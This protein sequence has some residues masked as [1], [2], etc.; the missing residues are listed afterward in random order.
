MKFNNVLET[1]GN[2]PLVK[3]NQVASHLKCHVWAKLEFMNPGGSIKDRIGYQMVLDAE[4]KGR[5]KPGDT[6]IE[7]TSGNTGIGLALVGAVRGYKVIITLPEKMSHEKVVVLETLGAKIIRTP[8]QATWDSPESHIGVAK[9][10]EKEI[11]NAHILDQYSNESN[12]KAHYMGTGREILEALD[13]KVDMVVMSAGTGGTITGV[14]RRVK[15]ANPKAIIVGADPVGSILAGPS[16]VKPYLVEGIGYDFVPDVL[17]RSLVDQWVKTED[18]PSFQL[19][20]RLIKEEGLLCGGSS[21]SALQAALETATQLK[22]GQNCVVL[23]PDGI[24]NYMT[25]FADDRW[26]VEHNLL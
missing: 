13:N 3:L 25:K 2:T 6:L 17:D 26:M 24:R 16:E 12:I 5:I 8:N 21:G 7:A 22:E 19:A 15:E 9:K 23:L 14:T 20:R 4:E 11:P 18:R 1:I 10:L